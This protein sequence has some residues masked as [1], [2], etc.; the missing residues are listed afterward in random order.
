LENLQPSN[1]T[2]S[3]V[4]PLEAGAYQ[5]HTFYGSTSN[6]QGNGIVV[7]N[8]GGVYIIGGYGN[9]GGRIAVVKFDTAGAYQWDDSIGSVGFAEGYGIAVD[10]SGGVYSTGY[11][12]ASWDGPAS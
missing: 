5:W 6:D 11:S 9:N 4:V 10:N 1:L 12:E 7:D 3:T 8:N 2:N